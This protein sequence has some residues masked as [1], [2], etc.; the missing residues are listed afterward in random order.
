MARKG[1]TGALPS[2][3]PRCHV[4]ASRNGWSKLPHLRPPT[5]PTPS[6][7]LLRLSHPTSSISHIIRMSAFTSSLRPLMRASHGAAS[8]ARSF[9]SSSSRSVSRMILTGRL[10]AEPELQATS[11]G[12]DIIR[13]AV[14]T[15]HGNRDNRQTS[16]FRIA[17]FTP[18]GPQRDYL[19]SLPKG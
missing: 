7:S 8:S 5:F 17:S 19:L 13:Y 9:S 14:G 3:P 6:H 1:P 16:W 11:T 12:Q 2:S 15:S 4:S 10:A 18:E